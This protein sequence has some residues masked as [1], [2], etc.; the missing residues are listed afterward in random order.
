LLLASSAAPAADP[1]AAP[2]YK[3]VARIPL[4]APDK[5]DFVYF[6][7]SA[8]RVYVSHG[9]EVT[10]VD[11]A[12][13]Q[14]VGH[15]TG[16]DRSHGIVTVPALGRGYADSSNPKTVIVFD[17]KTLKPVSTLPVGEDSDAMV[18]DAST[19]RV[20]VMDGDGAAFSVI[21]TV[22]NKT[23]STLPLG[24]KPES[25]VGDDK[26]N[27]Y[28][29]LASTN[30]M[31]RVNAATLAVE[32]RWPLPGCQSPHGLSMDVATQRLFVSCANAV[33]QVVA[34]DTGKV[35]ATLPIGKGT[36]ADAF[37]PTRKRAFSANGDGTLSI[38]A[39]KDANSF[40]ALPSVRTVPG[41]RTIAVDPATGR[42]FLVA[43][44]VSDTRAAKPAP[45][46]GSLKLLVLEPSD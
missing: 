1:A 29:N 20:F 28:V 41:A 33:M 2:A 32:A 38:V 16:L 34:S 40:V 6:D 13:G 3:I 15:V 14:I 37:D 9:T 45:V 23:I 42:V 39:E 31:V 26:G 24:G 12:G 10:V 11:P 4:G 7:S 30:A 27:I 46:P 17:L 21:D 35:V 43:G 19:K 5:F 25:A 36:D 44:D 18:Y 22:A 8:N